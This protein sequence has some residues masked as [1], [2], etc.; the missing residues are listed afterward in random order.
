ML[1]IVDL[2]QEN[3]CKIPPTS[4]GGTNTGISLPG[5]NYRL[6]ASEAVAAFGLAL[7]KMLGWALVSLA[8]ATWSGL[9]RRAG[10]E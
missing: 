9:F 10:R 1:P 6:F 8:I 5:G 4:T 7:Y 3:L 2:G